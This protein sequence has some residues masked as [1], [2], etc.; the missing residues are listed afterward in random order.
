ME[1]SNIKEFLTFSKE[2]TFII[3]QGMEIPKKVSIFCETKTP[4]TN[5]IFSQEKSFLI[6]PETE[7]LTKFFIFQEMELSVLKK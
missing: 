2:K 7:T 5:F 1:L 4:H 6:F 3:F